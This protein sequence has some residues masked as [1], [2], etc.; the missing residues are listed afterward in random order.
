MLFKAFSKENSSQFL[1]GSPYYKSQHFK[2]SST[3]WLLIYLLMHFLLRAYYSVF[4]IHFPVHIIV[5]FSFSHTIITDFILKHVVTLILITVAAWWN[6][7]YYFILACFIV[8]QKSCSVNHLV[9]PLSVFV[10]FTFVFIFAVSVKSQLF[11]SPRK[12]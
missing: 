2:I 12:K 10:Y 1:P 4:V 5:V 8:F 6:F 7:I 11:F 3:S 9:V